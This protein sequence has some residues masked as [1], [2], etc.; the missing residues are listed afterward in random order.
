MTAVA[1]SLRGTDRMKS[2]DAKYAKG[3]ERYA[4]SSRNTQPDDS[5]S[6]ISALKCRTCGKSFA[7]PAGH[8]SESSAALVSFVRHLRVTPAVLC[9]LGQTG[10]RNQLIK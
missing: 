5:A 6:E 2:V 3:K 1:G 4:N 10:Q 7:P 9:V 8:A